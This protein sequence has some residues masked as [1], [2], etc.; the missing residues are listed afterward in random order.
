MVNVPIYTYKDNDFE[1]P[2]SVSYVSEGFVP[3]R[4]TGILGLNWFLNCGGSIARE[5]K[6][7][8][9]DYID[10]NSDM[11]GFIQGDGIS[12]YTFI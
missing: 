3:S 11:N 2:I 4:Q 8:P 10:S 5:I 12:R 6:G 7:I 1:L 9:D